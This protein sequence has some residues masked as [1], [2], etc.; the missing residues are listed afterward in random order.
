MKR[1]VV[2]TF[3]QYD[4]LDDIE[5]KKYDIKAVLDDNKLIYKDNETDAEVHITVENNGIHIHRICD[6]ITD[7]ELIEGGIAQAK[8]S[9][10]FGEMLFNTKLLEKVTNE[11]EIAIEYQLLG[12]EE[13][14]THKKIIWTIGQ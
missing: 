4:Y 14:I 11:N 8:V 3:T 5:E 10:Q 1:D 7:I 12:D 9:S 2:I 13:I 6:T